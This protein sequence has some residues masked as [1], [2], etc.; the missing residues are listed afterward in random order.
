MDTTK[1]YLVRWACSDTARATRTAPE[2]PSTQWHDGYMR[3]SR[4][5]DERHRRSISSSPRVLLTRVS[6]RAFFAFHAMHMSS[7]VLVWDAPGIAAKRHLDK[8][9]PQ[10]RRAQQRAAAGGGSH[11]R[12]CTRTRHDA[13]VL[14]GHVDV[15]CRC[16]GVAVWRCAGWRACERYPRPRVRKKGCTFG[17]RVSK[18]YSA[19]FTFGIR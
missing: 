8:S 15:K 16:G 4:T 12:Q 10:D 14:H 2:G 11:A 13:V 6:Q 19:E 3:A 1:T 18:V 9:S 5:Q 17:T 7:S